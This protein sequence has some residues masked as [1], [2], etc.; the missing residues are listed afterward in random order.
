MIE[1]Y[2]P[3]AGQWKYHILDIVKNGNYP[4]PKIKNLALK[5]VSNMCPHCMMDKQEIYVSANWYGWTI[6]KI[7]F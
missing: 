5:T 2:F 3:I 7:Y 6:H 4:N 1:T